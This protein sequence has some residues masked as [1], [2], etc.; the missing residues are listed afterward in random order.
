MD[1]E[2]AAIVRRIFAMCAVGSG[3]SQIAR[4]LKNEQISCPAVYAYRKFGISHSTMNLE[5]PC[6]WSESTIAA[7]LENEEH[8]Q[9]EIQH[10]IL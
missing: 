6:D 4:K 9:Y 10:E 8:R 5:C 2:S 1:D 3:P 7:M